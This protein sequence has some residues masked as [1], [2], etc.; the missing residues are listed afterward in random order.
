M[1]NEEFNRNEYVTRD[2]L[3][4][5]RRSRNSGILLTG[6]LIGLLIAG[7]YYLAGIYGF[8]VDSLL[9]EYGFS[10]IGG[11]FATFDHDSGTDQKKNTKG[12]YSRDYRTADRLRSAHLSSDKN[13][14]AS[15]DRPLRVSPPPLRIEVYPPGARSSPGSPGSVQLPDTHIALHDPPSSSGT[16]EN[17]SDI[18]ADKEIWEATANRLGDV[19]EQLD[20]QQ[21]QIIAAR[22][23]IDELA[24][25]MDQARLPF[26]VAKRDGPLQVGPVRL[27]LTGTNAKQQTYSMR[28]FL[29]DHWVE[30]KDRVSEE[31][32]RFAVHGVANGLSLVVSQVYKGRVEG[33]LS[34]PKTR[35]V[36]ARSR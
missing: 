1:A 11:R 9:Q 17:D 23:G 30:L 26:Q 18:Q 29:D 15:Q 2:S 27:K 6:A 12:T 22:D 10:A 3:P 32:V 35:T 31:E 20:Q 4:H 34:L 13:E 25:R 16:S 33:Y 5:R 7:L 21:N 36:G 19:V 8:P 24:A 28:V 14:A